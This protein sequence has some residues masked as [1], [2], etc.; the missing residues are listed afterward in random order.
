[1]GT[2][3]AECPNCDEEIQAHTVRDVDLSMPIVSVC[4]KCGVKSGFAWELVARDG[5]WLGQPIEHGAK[6]GPLELDERE[7]GNWRVALCVPDDRVTQRI[8][9]VDGVR[10]DIDVKT[11]AW[12]ASLGRLIPA[13]AG[14]V[15]MKRYPSSPAAIAAEFRVMTD[16]QRAET[17]ALLMTD[18][19]LRSV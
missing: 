15:G 13:D 12:I 16:A 2:I 19:K 1:M 5:T 8:R 18:F 14:A 11:R 9:V 3:K 17:V 6:A 7:S 10:D 4:P